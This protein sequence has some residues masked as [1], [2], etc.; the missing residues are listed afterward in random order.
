M[1]ALLHLLTRLAPLLSLAGAKVVADFDNN[2]CGSFFYK[3]TQPQM[4]DCNSCDKICQIYKDVNRFATLYDHE[5]RI[6]IYS[7]YVFNDQFCGTAPKRPS[8]WFI[9]PQLIDPNND[10]NMALP[11]DFE[12]VEDKQAVDGDYKNTAFDRGHLNPNFY[13]CNEG[14][15]ATFTLTNAVPMDACFNR[16]KWYNYEKHTKAI[17]QNMCPSPSKAYLITGVVP[18]KLKIP[19]SPDD[20]LEDEPRTF[21]RIS[22]PLYV[23]TAVCCDHLDKDKKF[24]FGYFGYNLPQ[25]EIDLLTIEDLENKLKVYYSDNNL[26]L[27]AGKCVGNVKVRDNIIQIIRL[28][29]IKTYAPSLSA[30]HESFPPAQRGLP[31]KRK[32]ICRSGDT[33]IHY[34]PSSSIVTVRGIPCRYNFPCGKYGQSYFWC[35]TDSKNN[36]DYC[37]APNSYCGKHTYLYNWCYTDTIHKNYAKCTDLVALYDELEKRAPPSY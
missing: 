28:K 22:V 15:N 23:W 25:F 31:E 3:S 2:W 19:I 36:W 8:A 18:S 17:L 6:P 24:S 26:E 10:A 32:R 13:Q 34:S 21:D 14:R 7:A 33:C 4:R 1:A 30:I 35:Y 9:E 11:K 20:W 37:C 27:F 29:N 5:K 16:I 12:G